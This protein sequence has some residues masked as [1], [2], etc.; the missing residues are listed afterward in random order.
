MR[1]ETP[2]FRGIVG[3]I[4]ALGIA[5]V[6]ITIVSGTVIQWPIAVVAVAMSMKAI[7]AINKK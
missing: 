6:S 1:N 7:K 5:C 3:L 4:G 2:G